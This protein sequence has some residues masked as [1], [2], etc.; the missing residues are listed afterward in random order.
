MEGVRGFKKIWHK[1]WLHMQFVWT[2]EM[3]KMRRQSPLTWEN[4]CTYRVAA[5]RVSFVKRDWHMASIIDTEDTPWYSKWIHAP[6]GGWMCRSIPRGVVYVLMNTVPR[7]HICVLTKSTSYVTGHAKGALT[8]KCMCVTPTGQHF[9]MI[10]R[11]SSKTV[12]SCLP[13]W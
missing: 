9:L 2:G 8:A 4:V 6:Q 12:V 3:S 5:G 7:T 11:T 13:V 10:K 1:R